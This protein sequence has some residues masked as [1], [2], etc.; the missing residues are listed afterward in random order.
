MLSIDDFKK[1]TLDD[2]KIF[3]KHYDKYPPTHS[4]NV[5]TTLISWM[6]YRKYKYTFHK[7]SIIIMSEFNNQVRFRPPIGKK[8]KE[9]FDELLEIS[10]KQQSIIPFG[11][12]DSETKK[13]LSKSYPKIK[14]TPDRD[15]FEYVYLS[16]DLADLNGSDYKKIRNRLN[17][18]T[19]K[20]QFIV[21]T[22][23]EENMGE[24]KKFLKRWCL[25]KDCESDK[26]LE[27]E[28]KAV[29]YS[30][31]NFFE[32]DLSGIFIRI[33]DSIEAISVF[34]RMNQDTAVIHYEKGTPHYDGIY[35]AINKEAAILLQNNFSFINR[36]ADMGIPGLRRAKLSYSPHHMI[37]IYYLN[38]DNL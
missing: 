13:W 33:D 23:D 17:K 31:N 14:V 28:K 24:I 30:I 16:S 12:I 11:F 7:D 37:K 6:D 19:K 9:V 38:K 26:L 4:D 27:Y 8:K 29:F 10:K 20:N 1:I 3:D 15:F 25:W 5:F 18:F 21:E 34:E 35:K 36:E 32:L 22:I 2:K